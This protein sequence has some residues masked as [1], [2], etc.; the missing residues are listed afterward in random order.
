[1]KKGVII[2]LLVAL[3]AVVVIVAVILMN[4]QK[5]TL[6]VAEVSGET[7]QA[8]GEEVVEPVVEEKEMNPYVANVPNEI[9]DAYK[10]KAMALEQRNKDEQAEI[11]KDNPDYDLTMLGK[12]NYDLIFF[13]DDDIPELVV[14]LPGYRTTLYTYR[15]GKVVNVMR[16]SETDDDEYGWPFG[17]GGNH[18]YDYIPRGN[19]MK[20]ENSDYAGMILYITYYELDSKDLKL[21]VKN[22]GTLYMGHFEDKNGNGEID[23]EEAEKFVEETT[24]YRNGK[25]IT[26]EEWK[27]YQ[28]E[29]AY[30]EMVGTKSYDDFM[31]LLNSLINMK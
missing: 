12:L 20:N 22:D 23:E 25:V 8:S 21:A 28:F 14:T 16:E 6:P 26:E 17:A 27:T 15:D 5:P 13:D 31:P 11:L 3:I 30:E 2:G 7:T 1:M 29:G 4:N 24:L 9:V 18:G 19:T 10:E